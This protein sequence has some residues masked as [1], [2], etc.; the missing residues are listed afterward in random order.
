MTRLPSITSTQPSVTTTLLSHWLFISLFTGIKLLIQ[1]PAS[2]TKPSHSPIFHQHSLDSGTIRYRK[3]SIFLL[4]FIWLAIQSS[5]DEVSGVKKFIKK[6]SGFTPP[7]TNW[8]K[9]LV[10]FTVGRPMMWRE[11]APQW[12][13]G[14]PEIQQRDTMNKKK[15]KKLMNFWVA[16]VG[17]CP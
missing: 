16:P 2:V 7:K 3:C 5:R 10:T 4:V 12:G 6:V 13:A 15:K 14:K 1:S 11:R 9:I 8:S 17:H